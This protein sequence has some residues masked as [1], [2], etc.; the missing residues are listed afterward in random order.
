MTYIDTLFNRMDVWR[1]L[2]NYQLERRADLFF[3]LYLPETLEAKLGF[4]VS[5]TL[6]PEF[7]IRIGTIYPDIPI[8]KSYKID[9]VAI[10]ADAGKAIFV[11]LKTE[12][13]SRRDNQ[14][15]YLLA[16][17]EAGFPALL[18]G[19]LDIFRATHS[20]DKYYTLLELLESVGQLRV[21]QEMKRIMSL[22]NPRG[23]TEASRAVE[24]STSVSE[25]RIVYVQP[26]GDED[27]VISFEYFRDVVRRH[28]DPLSQR[29]TQSLKE[30]AAFKAGSKGSPVGGE[31]W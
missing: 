19:V 25:S 28:D 18:A 17:R 22:P 13:R 26:Y 9:Y 6:I 27:N 1:H 23:V 29:F 14:D 2:P 15:K 7:P 10:S 30:W 12:S 11:E 8:D 20:K 24:I 4:P 16:A 5:H 31:G 3:S 21:P